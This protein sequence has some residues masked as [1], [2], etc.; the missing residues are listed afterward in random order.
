MQD[1]VLDEQVEAMRGTA[2]AT[3][4]PA[5]KQDIAPLCDIT[6]SKAQQPAR[7][8]SPAHKAAAAAEGQGWTART[9]RRCQIEAT[10]M[11][12]AHMHLHSCGNGKVP[13]GRWSS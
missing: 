8:A 3:E 11:H 7:S 12:F 1:L 6:N 4:E 13:A 10:A 9:A 5:N 2:E